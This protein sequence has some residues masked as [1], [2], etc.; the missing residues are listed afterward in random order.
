MCTGQDYDYHTCL[1]KLLLMPRTNQVLVVMYALRFPPCLITCASF[2]YVFMGPSFLSV[3]GFEI[4]MLQKSK[5]E[6]CV[7]C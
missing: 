7:T 1:R 2:W 3:V 4:I 6:S 5:E